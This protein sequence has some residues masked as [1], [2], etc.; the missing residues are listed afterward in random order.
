[1]YSIL[2]QELALYPQLGVGYYPV[3]SDPK[4]VYDKKY[5][6]RYQKYSQ[7][8]V[9]SPVTQ[10]LNRYRRDLVNSYTQGEV[11]DVGIGAGTFIEYRGLNGVHNIRTLGYDVNPE[12]I[13]WLKE[14]DLWLDPYSCESKSIEAM[15]LWDVIEHIKD[16]AP[17]LKKL[18]EG[19]LLFISTPIY[20][21]VDYDEIH[22]SKHFRPTEHFWYFTKNGLKNF[23]DLCVKGKTG[24]KMLHE[25]YQEVV[26]GRE[27]VMT[28]VFKRT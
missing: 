20:E 19:G 5:F 12:G 14:R 13:K 21:S 11:L 4:K 2:N 7:S 3:I 24:F 18:K 26:I 16:P 27:G 8:L 1:M 6:E 15:T 25:S 9:N 17:L 28:F 23:L 22:N 10:D